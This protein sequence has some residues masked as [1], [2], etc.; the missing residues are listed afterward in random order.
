M[1]ELTI[2]QMSERDGRIGFRG[3]F[4]GFLCGAYLAAAFAI[5]PTTSVLTRWTIYSGTIAACGHAFAV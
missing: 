5:T 1:Q 4:S 3:F 2:R